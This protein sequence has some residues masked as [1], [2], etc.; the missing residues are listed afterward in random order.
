MEIF[1]GKKPKI[2][3]GGGEKVSRPM[4]LGDKE[5][6]LKRK[7]G[8]DQFLFVGSLHEKNR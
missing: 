7:M 1:S 3:P 8:K 4:Q 5:S 2:R 6:F